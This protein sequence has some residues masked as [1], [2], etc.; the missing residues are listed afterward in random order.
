M[1]GP[2]VSACRSAR[3]RMGVSVRGGWGGNE[4]MRR[5]TTHERSTARLRTIQVCRNLAPTN[6]SRRTPWK[7]SPCWSLP[8]RW[9]DIERSGRWMG[10]MASRDGETGERKSRRGIGRRMKSPIGLAAI[11]FV[12]G[13]YIM[14]TL[15]GPEQRLDPRE[16]DLCS[17]LL[18][19][20]LYPPQWMLITQVPIL[21]VVR[22]VILL[23]RV[24]AGLPAD[25]ACS[26][27][28]ARGARMVRRVDGRG[29]VYWRVE[30][31]GREF[32]AGDEGGGPGWGDGPGF[33]VCG[34]FHSHWAGGGG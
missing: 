30:N 3:Q 20:L 24:K 28:R 18:G 22:L 6:P 29:R 1:V 31:V 8:M 33:Q 21:L 26:Q 19:P 2:I 7:S 12:S 11:S 5:S 16:A 9:R 13:S 17:I 4:R 15:H 25:R 14:P 32:G 23:H 10:R 34:Y 27:V